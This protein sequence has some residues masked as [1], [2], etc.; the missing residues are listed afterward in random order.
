MF[1]SVFQDLKSRFPDITFKVHCREGQQLFTDFSP[2]DYD[3]LFQ[4]PMVQNDSG[5]S[6]FRICAQQQLGIPWDSSKEFSYQ[7][8]EVPDSGIQLPENTFAL[9]FQSVSNK[10]KKLSEERVNL[11]WNKVKEFGFTPLEVQFQHN[12]KST[13]NTRYSCIDFTCRDFPASIANCIDVMRRCRGFIGVHT[14]T[15]CIAASLYPD[16]TLHLDINSHW[17]P[18]VQTDC[19]SMELDCSRDT[20]NILLLQRFLQKCRSTYV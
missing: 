19:V 14:G 4:V 5:L 15:S 6:K 7:L 13:W 10:H 8:P 20:L 2:G 9:S 1:W 11:I 16:K 12:Y 17:S 3:I 18:K